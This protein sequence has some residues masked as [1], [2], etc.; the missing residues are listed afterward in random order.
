MKKILT[1]E[2]IENLASKS[3]RDYRS[4]VLSSAFTKML[5]MFLPYSAIIR[6]LHFGT[7]LAKSQLKVHLKK[8]NVIPREVIRIFLLNAPL[9][10][11]TRKVN[12]K[13]KVK[14]I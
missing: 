4:E 9:R 11:K 10:A 8:S 7:M 14:K 2:P 5:L 3:V 1:F 6:K 13:R 12:K